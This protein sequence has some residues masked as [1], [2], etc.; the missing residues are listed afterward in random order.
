M[1]QIEETDIAFRRQ[2]QQTWWAI[3]VALGVGILSLILNA[4]TL[5]FN[6]HDSRARNLTGPKAF[7]VEAAR[8]QALSACQSDMV[9]RLVTVT[10][11]QFRINEVV[12]ALTNRP[13]VATNTVSAAIHDADSRG[14][15][16]PLFLRKATDEE[17]HSDNERYIRIYP[18][19]ANGEQSKSGILKINESILSVLPN[20]GGDTWGVGLIAVP[21]GPDGVNK[22]GIQASSYFIGVKGSLP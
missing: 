12:A 2:R 21:K 10:R 14:L 3:G 22:Q 4:G 11:E 15:Y 20:V 18:N 16:E 6:M 9:A 5:Y 7:D 19:G 13:P 1:R 8:W 17:W